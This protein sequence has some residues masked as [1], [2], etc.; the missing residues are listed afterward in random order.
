MQP[1]LVDLSKPSTDVRISRRLLSDGSAVTEYCWRDAENHCDRRL[2]VDA[3]GKRASDCGTG[4]SDEV[5]P[6]MQAH[7]V[8]YRQF[9]DVT[10]GVM[11]VSRSISPEGIEYRWETEDARTFELCMFHHIVFEPANDTLVHDRDVFV[12]DIKDSKAGVLRRER[13]SYVL[14]DGTSKQFYEQWQLPSGWTNEMLV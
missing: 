4:L 14:T 2:R 13:K 8:V 12:F 5:P 11:C 1:L 3:D 9:P 7:E 6:G 10:A